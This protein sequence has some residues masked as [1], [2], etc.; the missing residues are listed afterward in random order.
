MRLQPSTCAA[1]SSSTGMAARNPRSVTIVNGS[2]I[3]KYTP[4]SMASESSSWVSRAMMNT[5]T[6]SASHG[7]ICAANTAT[8]NAPL[9]RH[10]ILVTA[11]AAS[12]ATTSAISTAPTVTSRLLRQ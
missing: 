4:V 9:P 12:S 1:S 2:V 11:N 8:T 5:G 7:A 6:S 3:M 10:D